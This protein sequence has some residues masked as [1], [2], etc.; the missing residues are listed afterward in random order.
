MDYI[1]I[2]TIK[3]KE[4]EE[5]AETYFAMLDGTFDK[6]KSDLPVPV[7]PKAIISR[8]RGFMRLPD[9]VSAKLAPTGHKESKFRRFIRRFFCTIEGHPTASWE[10]M[11]S[12][13]VI[14]HWCDRT[15]IEKQP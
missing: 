6:Y 15:W 12:D 2:G 10:N 5:Q 13:I 9:F 3:R 4:Y 8:K 1:I 14:C 7:I 11:T